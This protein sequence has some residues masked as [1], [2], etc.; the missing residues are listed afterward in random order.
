MSEL[1]ACSVLGHA[2][3]G[4]PRSSRR[5]M[6]ISK[7]HLNVAL[8]TKIELVGYLNVQYIYVRYIYVVYTEVLNLLCAAGPIILIHSNHARACVGIQPAAV[9]KWVRHPVL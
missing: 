6:S 4:R 8:S 3:K 5:V 7:S 2:N 1:T 9:L